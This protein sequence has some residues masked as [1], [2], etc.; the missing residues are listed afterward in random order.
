MN[1]KRILFSDRNYRLLMMGQTVSTLGNSVSVFAFFAYTLTLTH[2]PFYASLVSGCVT[3]AIVVVG[4]PAGIW[5]DKFNPIKLILSSSLIGAL[6]IALAIYN[7]FI[8]HIT[9]PLV[10]VI[11]AFLV[12]SATAIFSSAEKSLLKVLV[13]SEYLGQAMAI[14]QTRYSIGTV[15]GPIVGA[16]L[17][18]LRPIFTFLFDFCTYIFAFFAFKSI[19]FSGNNLESENDHNKSSSNYKETLRVIRSDKILFATLWFTPMLNFSLSGVLN[20]VFTYLSGLNNGPYI[21]GVFQSYFGIIGLIG[22]AIAAMIISKIKGG[23]GLVLTVGS[24]LISF[25]GITLS[26]N[27]VSCFIFLGLLSLALPLFNS[28]LS[29][30]FLT[31]IP[32]KFIGKSSSAMTIAAM[33]LMP[34]GTWV[35]GFLIENFNAFLVNV[36]MLSLFLPV[37]IIFLA[38]SDIRN[39]SKSSDWKA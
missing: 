30:Y 5:A 36:F 6:G 12:G 24:F 23:L 39:L 34:V 2:S 28:I 4:I 33:G 22:S 8:F 25:V 37:A 16:F 3:L 9:I 13:K 20:N 27:T 11:T 1:E 14:N 17:H 21:L 7:H 26:F 32:Q 38:N 29:G 19:R 15:T 35:S 18:S 31:Y 10:L